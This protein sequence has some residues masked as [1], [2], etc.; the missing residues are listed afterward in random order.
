MLC[1]S[2]Q[3]NSETGKILAVALVLQTVCTGH[4]LPFVNNGVLQE[5]ATSGRVCETG[6]SALVVRWGSAAKGLLAAALG[7]K[8]PKPQPLDALIPCCQV[9]A[10][11][12]GCCSMLGQRK[13]KLSIGRM[14]E[15]WLFSL[16]SIGK[17]HSEQNSHCQ[18]GCALLCIHPLPP[19]KKLFCFF[20]YKSSRFL[21]KE[22]N[23][24]GHAMLLGSEK[25][26]F[27]YKMFTLAAR[28]L[29]ISSVGNE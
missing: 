4:L 28:F 20:S 25:I 12:V 6:E 24:H 22:L 16:K 1:A 27:A 11:L 3:V 2:V 18:M 23:Y 13:L 10:G 15:A 14:S 9:L 26:A 8:C 7:G 29:L 21:S 5:L 17:G 19:K